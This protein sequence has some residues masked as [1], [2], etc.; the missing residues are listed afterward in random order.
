[1]KNIRTLEEASEKLIPFAMPGTGRTRF[2][3]AGRN[4]QAMGNPAVLCSL[5]TF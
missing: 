5:G 3:K 2:E 4:I 1:V